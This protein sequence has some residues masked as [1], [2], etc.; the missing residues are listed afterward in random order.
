MEFHSLE[1]KQDFF[2]DDTEFCV[3]PFFV[4]YIMRVFGTRCD[5]QWE[6]LQA[7]ALLEHF[8]LFD[9]VIL[10]RSGKSHRHKLHGVLWCLSV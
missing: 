5:L 10:I 7:A 9:A 3:T 6:S 4:G 2:A 8:H 1:W